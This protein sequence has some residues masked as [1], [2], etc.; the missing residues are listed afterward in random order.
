MKIEYDDKYDMLYIRFDESLQDTIN[1]RLSD[2]IV[3]DIGSDN[4]IVGIEILDAKESLNLKSILPIEYIYTR[5]NQEDLA[6]V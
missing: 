1:Q 4:K 3:L 5:F 2:N 6:V